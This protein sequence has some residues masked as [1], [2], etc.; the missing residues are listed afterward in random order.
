MSACSSLLVPSQC[1]RELLLTADITRELQLQMS[2]K[3]LSEGV[4]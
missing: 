4:C 1:Y 2:E 3:S